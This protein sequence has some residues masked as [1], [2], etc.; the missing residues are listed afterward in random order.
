MKPDL[1]DMIYVSGPMSGIEDLNFPLFN[2]VTAALRARGYSALNPVET[3]GN[4]PCSW[5]RCIAKDLISFEEHNVTAICLLPGWWKS[6]GAWVEV[7]AGR[8]MK[9][10]ICRVQSLLPR[11]EWGTPR[12]WARVGVWVWGKLTEANYD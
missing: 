11:E 1:T 8:K 5:L 10:R 12:L 9:Y 3:E 6:Y 4:T 7:I 2:R